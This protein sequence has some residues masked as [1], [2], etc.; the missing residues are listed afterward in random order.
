[1]GGSVRRLAGEGNPGVEH[2]RN[3]FRLTVIDAADLAAMKRHSGQ[4]SHL[5]KVPGQLLAQEMGPKSRNATSLFGIQHS[6]GFDP[7][8]GVRLGTFWPAYFMG[9]AGQELVRPSDRR[10]P[11]RSRLGARGQA[12]RPFLLCRGKTSKLA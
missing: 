6:S 5:D 10:G 8:G 4:I 9:S 2:R 7:A 1:M 12:A 11:R 3:D